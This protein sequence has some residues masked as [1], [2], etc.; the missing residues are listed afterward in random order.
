MAEIQVF[1]PFPWG[2][3]TNLQSSE[4]LGNCGGGRWWNNEGSSMPLMKIE[5]GECSKLGWGLKQ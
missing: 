1:S 5:I 4:L 3:S 2:I